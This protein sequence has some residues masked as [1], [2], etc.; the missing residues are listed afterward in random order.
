MEG[1][2]HQKRVHRGERPSHIIVKTEQSL[3][4]IKYIHYKS[5]TMAFPGITGSGTLP[6]Q[7]VIHL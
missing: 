3:H 2:F 5:G 4:G 7:N 1:Y 6:R